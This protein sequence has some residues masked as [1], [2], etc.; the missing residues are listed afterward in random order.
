[1]CI[2]GWG[3]LTVHSPF[4]RLR[5]SASWLVVKKSRVILSAGFSIIWTKLIDFFT[6]P[7][8]Y[9]KNDLDMDHFTHC[10]IREELW[11]MTARPPPGLV[12]WVH[13]PVNDH[14]FYK[15]IQ[16]TRSHNPTSWND[17]RRGWPASVIHLLR[18]RQVVGWE[19]AWEGLGRR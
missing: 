3:L 16:H 10:I 19:G 13:S 1:M 8:G 15:S 17:D 2:H 5:S 12:N 18:G 11:A 14:V 7:F 4:R 9:D 6:D